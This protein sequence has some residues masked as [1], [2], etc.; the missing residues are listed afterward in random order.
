M[1]PKIIRSFRSTISLQFTQKGELIVKTPFYTPLFIIKQFIKSK[2]KWIIE[3]AKKQEEKVKKK[4]FIEGEE[5]LYLGNKYRLRIVND[6]EISLS[7]TLNFPKVLLFRAQK[8]MTNWYIRQAGNIITQRLKYHTEKIRTKYSGVMFSDTISKWGSCSVD[9]S[10]QFN[11][12]LVMTPLVVLDYV[13][14]HELVHTLEKNHG[15]SF[16]KKV[17]FHTPAFK[18]HRKWLNTNAHLLRF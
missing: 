5:F 17:S 2:E 3:N 7:D 15:S 4:Q 9:N 8:E 16:W 10:L 1:D 12:R 6:I 18:Q 11:W 14:I 13:V